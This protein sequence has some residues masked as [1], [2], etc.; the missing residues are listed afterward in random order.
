MH[1]AVIE[2][3]KCAAKIASNIDC[4]VLIMSIIVFFTRERWHS[5][6]R[7]SFQEHCACDKRKVQGVHEDDRHCCALKQGGEIDIDLGVSI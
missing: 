6:C 4:N 2:D 5:Y 7:L 3:H 1:E